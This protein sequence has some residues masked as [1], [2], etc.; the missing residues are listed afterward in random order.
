M[1]R[2]PSAHSMTVE[3]ETER[4]NLAAELFKLQQ[5]KAEAVV[6]IGKLEGERDEAVA[7]EKAARAEIIRLGDVIDTL[8]ADRDGLRVSLEAAEST[9]SYLRSTIESGNK[10]MAEERSENKALKRERDGLKAENAELM[11]AHAAV[12][13]EW[14][15]DSDVANHRFNVMKAVVEAVVNAI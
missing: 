2:E 12:T 14:D 13:K 7:N 11:K 4:E 8:V 9:I 5:W 10:M 3:P 15:R 6:T 1:N